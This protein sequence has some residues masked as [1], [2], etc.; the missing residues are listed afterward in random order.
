MSDNFTNNQKTEDKFETLLNNANAARV[1]SSAVE[2]TLGP[3]GLDIMMVDKFGDVV[4]TNDGVTILKLME[5]NHPAAHMIINAAKAQ[6]SEIGDGTTTTTIMAGALVAEGCQQVLKGVPVTKVIAGINHGISKAIDLVE[7]NAILLN[8]N[9]ID[10]LYSVAL[11]AGRGH[12]E[13]ARLIVDGAIAIGLN[14]LLEPEYKFSDAVL[15]REFANNEVIKGVILNKEP[16]NKEMPTTLNDLKILVIDDNLAPEELEAEAIRTEAGFNYYLQAKKR[17]QDNLI[18][19]KELGVNVVIVDRAIDDIAEE[20]FTQAGIFA[21]HRVSSREIERLCKYT[22]ARK[23]K[24]SSLNRPMETI[25]TYLGYAKAIKVDEKLEHTI[26]YGG[27]AENWVTVMIG[28]ATEEVVDEKERMA[29]DA[30]AALQAAWRGGIVPGGGAIE[31]WTS[32]QLEDLAKDLEGMT[33]YGVNCVKEAIARPFACIVDNAGFNPLEKLGDLIAKQRRENSSAIGL[34]SETGQ[35]LNMVEC[36]IVDPV[37]VKVHAIKAA[38][39]VATAILR[40]NTIIRMKSHDNVS[41]N[42]DMF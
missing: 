25:N 24:R 23:V 9:D 10:L 16:V 18:K 11:I 36:G 34:D 5:V 42:L 8:E 4:I 12:E 19:I 14:C 7:S 35:F 3:K 20:F 6:Q 26:I 27:Q 41:N 32:T 1:I 29:K 28:A 2:G 31:I 39:E 40:I 13:L 17:Y 30:A 15:A 37:P 33:S 22:G 21:L 38:G